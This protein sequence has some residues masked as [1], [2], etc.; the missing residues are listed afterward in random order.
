MTETVEA[1]EFREQTEEP[2]TVLD[3]FLALFRADAPDIPVLPV[4]ERALAAA[5]EWLEGAP[6]LESFAETMRAVAETG[7][8]AGLDRGSVTT[9]RLHLLEH[10]Q[11]GQLAKVDPKSVL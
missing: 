1:G 3:S 8:T 2:V 9:L 7:S 10:C 5:A 6:G 4:D 11:D